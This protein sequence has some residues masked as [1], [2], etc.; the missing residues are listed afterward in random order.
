MS[1]HKGMDKEDVTSIYRYRYRWYNIDID[2]HTTECYSAI[3]KGWNNAIC[4][5][6][7]GPRDYH[8]KWS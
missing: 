3:K 6:M 1:N 8:T 2:T 7:D 4:S 5:K